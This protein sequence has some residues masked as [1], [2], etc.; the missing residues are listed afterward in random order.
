MTEPLSLAIVGLGRM[1]W[2]HA[3]NAV[4]LAA[5][6]ACRVTALV[7]ADQSRATRFAQQFVPQA[8]IFSS[9]EELARAG[10]AQA[11]VVV[12]PTEAHRAHAQTLLEGG[13]RILLEKPLTGTLAGDE[14]FCRWLEDHHPSAV[15]LAFQRRFDE[16]LTYGRDL[17]RSGLIGRVFKIDSALEDSGPPP[18]GYRSGGILPDMSVHNIDEILWFLERMPTAAL[19]IG[20]R[21][22]ASQLGIVEEDFD[23]ALLHLWFHDLTAQIQVSR[24]HVSGYRVET[25]LYGEQGQ[26]Q[27]GR[28]DQRPEQVTVQAFGLRGATQPLAAKI[29]PCDPTEPGDPEFVQ[30]FGRAYKAELAAFIDCCRK[31]LPFPTS[32]RDALRAQ[33]VVAAAMNCLLTAEQ[34]AALVASS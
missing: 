3:R 19:A 5:A 15:M 2:I 21:L 10:L 1:G 25:I 12:T 20:A 22:Y 23:D 33:R 26:I 7:D 13:L 34:A 18:K 4:Q 6:G 28:F 16:A 9:V 17:M 24:N 27:I 31:Q 8:R 11:A 32:H 30:R 14:D 29:F